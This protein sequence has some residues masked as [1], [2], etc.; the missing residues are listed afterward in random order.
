MGETEVEVEH[1]E[2]DDTLIYKNNAVKYT[3]TTTAG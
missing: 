1:K 3:L 2:L